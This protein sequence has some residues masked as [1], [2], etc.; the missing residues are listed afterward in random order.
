MERNTTAPKV[1]DILTTK[2]IAFKP[3]FT[4]LDAIQNFNK[5]RI[6]TAPVINK[7]MQVIGF[8]SESDLLKCMSN[9]LFYDEYWNNKTID[10]IMNKQVVTVDPEWDIFELECFFVSKHIRC[11]PVVDD[12]N[13]L[14]G[15]ITKRDALKALG[16]LL[17]EREK[18]KMQIKTPLVLT[19]QERIKIILERLS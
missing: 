13:H 10:E 12:Q 4:Q 5:Y 1:K 19:K 18:Y 17:Q 14:I 11:A 15:I 7:E 2:V 9:S 3:D 16:N 8:I 6:S